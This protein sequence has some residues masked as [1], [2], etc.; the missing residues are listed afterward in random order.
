MKFITYAENTFQLQHLAILVETKKIAKTELEVIV[1]TAAISRYSENTLAGLLDMIALN[2]K[3]KLPLVLE[4]DVLQQESLFQKN[5]ELVSRLPLH[6]FKAV[7]LQDPGALNFVKEK[8]P[9]LKIQLI[10]ENGNHNYTGLSRWSEFLGEQLDRLVLSN[11]LSREHL[12]KYAAELKT[13]LEV[14]VFGR[15]L[16]FYSPRLLLSPIKKEEISED[17]FQKN[18]EAFGSSEE[19]P[20]NGFPLIENR[21]GT[22]M[23]NVK[24]LYLLDHLDELGTLNIGAVRFDLRFDNSFGHLENCLDLFAGKILHEDVLTIKNEHPR[25]MIKGFYNINK[26]DVLFT[27][28]KNK[29]V[30]R[31]DDN[32]I[33]EIVDVERDQQ[34]ALLIKSKHLVLKLGD[35][36]QL[37]T[38]EGK[39]KTLGLKKFSDTSGIEK[40]YAATNEVVLLP[41]MSGVVAKTQVYLLSKNLL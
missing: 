27:K 21:H 8:F 13:E 10:L 37:V 25:P 3:L 36:L 15:I 16:L 38:P 2:Q 1:G 9:W 17:L 11:E 34:M 18:K 23:F 33:G 6:E 40:G 20:H 30:Q 29:R 4:W 39:T 31:Q 41:Y 35:E 26:T 7:R 14:L 5:A 12:S 32:Y 19:S 22:F 28:L 24:D